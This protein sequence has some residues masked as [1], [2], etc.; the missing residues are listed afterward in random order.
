VKFRRGCPETL[1]DRQ[2]LQSVELTSGEDERGEVD[3]VEGGQHAAVGDL[4]RQL[5]DAAGDLPQFDRA[6][7]AAMSRPASASRSSPATPSAA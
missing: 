2:E 3:R 6:Q 5:T 7:I 1:I 4:A